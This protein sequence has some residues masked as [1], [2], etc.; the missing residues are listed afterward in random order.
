MRSG[1]PK[2][3]LPDEVLDREIDIIKRKGVD[4]VLNRK[5]A[6]DD[7]AA[8]D[9]DTAVSVDVLAN[10]SDVDGDS[11]TVLTTQIGRASCRERV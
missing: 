10:D 1:I 4:I 3:R 5:V 6:I 9:E 7:I 2:F 8:T 11:L